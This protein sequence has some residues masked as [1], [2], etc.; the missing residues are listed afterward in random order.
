[1]LV[2]TGTLARK[3]QWKL[4]TEAGADPKV[5]HWKRVGT[6]SSRI[7]PSILKLEWGRETASRWQ[8]LAPRSWPAMMMDVL[9]LSGRRAL[10][11]SSRATPV[12]SLSCGPGRGDERPYPGIWVCK[13]MLRL[14]FNSSYVWD[15]EGYIRW[16][17]RNKLEYY[18]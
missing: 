13:L 6:I 18:Q 16:E 2:A 11:V 4:P 8:I 12:L 14:E 10:R 15:E 1:M 17:E 7:A 5:C 9:S 3:D